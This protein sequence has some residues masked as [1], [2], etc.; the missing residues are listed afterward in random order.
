MAGN[1][2]AM[3]LKVA[4]DERVIVDVTTS[5]AALTYPAMIL[6]LITALC[7][8]GIGF[9]DQPQ[10]NVVI[11]TGMRNLFVGLWALL[12]VWFF[13][14]PVLK[15]RRKRVILTDR[16]LILRASGFS[17]YS[18]SI[19]LGAIRMVGR[20]GSTITLGV[21]G[22][23]RMIAIPDVPKARKVADLIENQRRMPLMR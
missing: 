7:W 6:I 16:R 3:S 17:G 19:P 21:H 18:E 12:A 20:K 22:Y 4:K 13:V 15:L 23:G 11:D 10:P 14:R 8:M 9:I 1:V 2:K 5:L